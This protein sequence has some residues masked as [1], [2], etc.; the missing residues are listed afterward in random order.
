[1]KPEE[2]YSLLKTPAGQKFIEWLDSKAGVLYPTA[3]DGI[4]AA[5]DI[6]VQC[7]RKSMV[8]DI[9]QQIK[10]GQKTT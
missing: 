8:D 9:K 2:I 3:P 1:M 10:Q 6:S 5:M 4:K 7:G